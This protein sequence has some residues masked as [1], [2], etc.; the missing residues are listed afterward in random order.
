MEG[1]G[2]M[3]APLRMDQYR[4]EAERVHRVSKALREREELRQARVLPTVG[5]RRLSALAGALSNLVH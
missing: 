5:W 1:M 4:R 2:P 3:L